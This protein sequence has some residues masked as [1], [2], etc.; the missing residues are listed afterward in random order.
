MKSR[1]S[2]RCLKRIRDYYTR[3]QCEY[4]PLVKLKYVLFIVNE[5]INELVEFESA[6]TDFSNVS[7]SSLLPP[8][9]YSISKCGMYAFQIE[10]EYIWSLANRQLLTPET[11]FYLTLMSS[12]CYVLK[13]LEPS[14]FSPLPPPPPPPPI[15]CSFESASISGG[16]WSSS[17][18][19]SS[20]V[21]NNNSGYLNPGLLHVYLPDDKCQTLKVRCLPIRTN[22]KARE[23]VQMLVAKF[24]LYGNSNLDEYALSYMENGQEVRVRDDEKPFEIKKSRAAPAMKFIFRQ[25]SANFLWPKSIE[26]C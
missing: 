6:L 7:A 26:S 22:S 17:S 18:S 15:D 21:A 3:M 20:S 24:K 10:L 4:A 2:E 5:L 1:P 8:L 11:L 16:S 12:A 13:S 19:S 14:Q 23:C 9:I 25:R